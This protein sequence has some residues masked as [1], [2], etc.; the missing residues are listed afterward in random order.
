MKVKIKK[1]REKAVIPKYQTNGAS[2]FDLC[3]TCTVDIDPQETVLLQTGLSFERPE[4]YEMQIRPRSGLSFKT[5]LRVC[6]SPGTID[7]DYRGEVCIIMENT[8]EYTE[9]IKCGDRIA[10]GVICPIVQ[11]EFDETELNETER[12]SGGLGSTGV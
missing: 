1:L 10:Q 5:K 9:T 3:N 11:V 6:N 8:G 4:G 12:G 2:G 7:A